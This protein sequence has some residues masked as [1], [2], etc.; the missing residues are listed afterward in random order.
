MILAA[1]SIIVTNDYG[2]SFSLSIIVNSTV[3]LAT[4]LRVISILQL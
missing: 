3:M 1:T 4:G 2:K